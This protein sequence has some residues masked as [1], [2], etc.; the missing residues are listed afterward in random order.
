[1][2]DIFFSL[3]SIIVYLGIIISVIMITVFLLAFIIMAKFDEEEK[4]GE[5]RVVCFV[6]SC[7][8]FV[9]VFVFLVKRFQSI[10]LIF[11][12]FLFDRNHYRGLKNVFFLLFLNIVVFVCLFVFVLWRRTL[13]QAMRVGA[14]SRN[15]FFLSAAGIIKSTDGRGLETYMVAPPTFFLFSLSSM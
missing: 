13:K 8:C 9:F 5:T 11:I 1:M 10:F 14:Q 6:F 7:S 2:S 4:S 15:L 12:I 3:E